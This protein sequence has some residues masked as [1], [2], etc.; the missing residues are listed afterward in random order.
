MKRRI[1]LVCLFYCF[2]RLPIY[3]S[4]A[5]VFWQSVSYVF[6]LGL[7]LLSSVFSLRRCFLD[8][9]LFMQYT[10]IH[11]LTSPFS[12]VL[13]GSQFKEKTIRCVFC[14]CQ[15]FQIFLLLCLYDNVAFFSFAISL[16]QNTCIHVLQSL[17]Q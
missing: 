16:L 5:A 1:F 3:E 7:Q 6:V 9:Y 10:Y 2:F 11:V 14:F 12:T 4:I 13:L 15:F 17:F 8:C